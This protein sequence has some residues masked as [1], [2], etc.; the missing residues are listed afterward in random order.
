[1][2]KSLKSGCGQELVYCGIFEPNLFE[3]RNFLQTHIYMIH[4]L[5]YWV[6]NET[7]LS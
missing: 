6:I 4:A 3:A 5:F 1:M 2:W 7:K